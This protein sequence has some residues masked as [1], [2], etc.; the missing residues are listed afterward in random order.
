AVETNLASKDSHWVYVNEEIT[1]NEILELVH[2]ALGRMTVIRQIFPLSRDNNQRCMRNNHRISSLLCDPQEGYLQ[3]LQVSN[4][5]LYDSVLMLANAFHRK[6]ED[7]KWHSMASLNCMRK[8]TKPWNGGRSMLETIKK[9]HITGLTGVM[10]FREDG[11]NPY[12]QFEILGTSYS[13]TF[14][15]DVRR[16]A[17]WDSEKGLNGSLQERRLGNDLQGLTLKVVTV[18]E[19]PFVMV[20]ENILG[21]PKR[22]KGFS[23]DVL[24]ALAKNLGFKY[25][26]YQAPD[27]KY[28][29]QLQNSS[30]NG[31]IGELI[32]K[33]ADL[34]IS[35]ITITPERESV[36][37]F[38]KRYMDYSVGILIKKPEEKI[39]IFSLFAP[40]D[41]AVWACIAAAIP[42]VG[43]LIFVLNRIQ[44]VR[45]QNASQP[46]P[47]ASSTLHSA[48]WVVYGAFVQQ[49]GESTVNSVAMRIVMGSWWLFTLIVCSSYTANLAAFLTVSRMDNPIRTFQDLSKQMDISYGTV[50]DS[51][52]YEY[53]KAKG[54]N[55]LEQDNTFAELWRTI[56]KNNGA[57]N[58]V[59]NPSEGIRK[60][61]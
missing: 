4:L 56:S 9:G 61:R 3:M 59:S 19:E 32:N 18:L 39:N 60:V 30:W 46:S 34:A 24:D 33:R 40:F 47:S 8:S 25:E 5:Y 31:M 14:G 21:Q 51:A 10:E 53:F 11:A 50:R 22:Y 6:L 29:Q 23:I 43:V 20:A 49:G 58:C 16:L 12:V 54:T 52:V 48:I 26:I 36:V 44:A 37:D 2:S 55:P 15:K 13:E 42:I 1:D 7:R 35:A 17:T 45:A 41:F 57:D 38:S 27:G 28:G